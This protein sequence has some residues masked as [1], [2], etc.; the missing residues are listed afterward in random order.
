MDRNA[1]DPMIRTI[2][3]LAMTA[4]MLLAAAA[5]LR[6][7]PGRDSAA[8]AGFRED[9]AR[10]PFD[11]L[12]RHRAELRLS[13]QQVRQI[14]T[15][16][17]RLEERNAPLRERLVREH[18]RWREERRTQL[19]RMSPEERRR[20]LRRVRER[21]GA[22]EQVPEP[23]RPVVREM[24]VNVEEAIHEAQGVLTAEQRVQV[25]QI[26]RRELRQDRVR[27]RRPFRERRRP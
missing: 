6:A 23:L 1:C 2:V 13:P 18:G 9:A 4:L 14:E 22:G 3:R 26:L 16:A 5:P 10:R 19:E 20:E 8:A 17:R 12:L 15:V 27:A 21:R 25:R 24:L 7:Q 11:A